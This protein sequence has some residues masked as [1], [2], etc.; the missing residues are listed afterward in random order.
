MC[1]VNDKNR[2]LASV[3]KWE[4]ES[5]ATGRGETEP[6]A[7][8]GHRPGIVHFC[9]HTLYSLEQL[10]R[11]LEGVVD[12]QTFL[13]RLGLQNRRVFRDAAWG[14]EI[15]E[16]AGQARGFAEVRPETVANLV[17]R[18]GRPGGRAG[19]LSRRLVPQDLE[20]P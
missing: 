8:T 5:G 19:R 13:A 14:W 2:P 12:L 6:E 16:A 10:G 7:D 9:P 1:N 3:P 15:L 11:M 18:T 17:S 4:R 20:K